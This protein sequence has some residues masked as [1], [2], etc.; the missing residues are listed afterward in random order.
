[1][2]SKQLMLITIVAILARQALA[3]PV[4][5]QTYDYWTIRCESEIK[6]KNLRPCYLFQNLIL[7]EG[8]SRVLH[9]AAG[10]HPNNKN[11]V[12]LLVTMPLGISLPPGASLQV[13][14]HKPIKFMIERCQPEGCRGG[15]KLTEDMKK[16]LETGKTATVTFYD[17]NRKPIDVSISLNGFSEGITALN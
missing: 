6:K 5:G 15:F 1:M 17:G 3:A 7:R 14:D 4:D 10:L 16:Q 12:I 9:I 2:Y 8:G 13:D 11:L